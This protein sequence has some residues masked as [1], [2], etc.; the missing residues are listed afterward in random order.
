VPPL[1]VTGF[2]LG[3]ANAATAGGAMLLFI[4]NFSAIVVFA[5]IVFLLLGYARV[6][7]PAIELGFLESRHG[8]TIQLAERA[9]VALQ[10]AFGSQY[11]LA[12]RLLIPLIFLLLVYVPLSRA[13]DDVARQVRVRDAVRRVLAAESPQAVQTAFVIDGD[14]ALLR[15]LLVGSVDEAERLQRVLTSRI[16]EASGIR[17]SVAVTAVPD[18][19]ALAAQVT[20]VRAASPPPRLD[21][22]PIRERVAE[23]LAAA[24]P[25]AA[26]ELAGWSVDLTGDSMP[27][28]TVRH[29]GGGGL[30]RPHPARRHRPADVS[31]DAR[32][33]GCRDVLAAADARAARRGGARARPRRMRRR[34]ARRPWPCRNA[35]AGDCRSAP[36]HPRGP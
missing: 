7:A 4:A 14:T 19:G 24:W 29:P 32:R 26:G 2:G 3:T 15:L 33:R 16:S 27:T 17:P 35:G 30:R 23:V 6:D 18:A 8:G 34:A 13:L 21:F 36:G 11:G 1:C 10:R 28:L 20:A 25:T 22:A 9:H 5:V 31:A 12:T